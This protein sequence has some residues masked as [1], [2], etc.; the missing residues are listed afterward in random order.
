M[1]GLVLVSFTTQ[2]V[3]CCSD[4]SGVSKTLRHLTHMTMEEVW[5]VFLE[6][7]VQCSLT[8]EVDTLTVRAHL[9]LLSTL[10]DTVHEA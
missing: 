10:C 3:L 2:R 4:F 9:F 7:V 8:V 5:V 6:V 1:T